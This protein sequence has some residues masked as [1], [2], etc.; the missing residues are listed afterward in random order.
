MACVH[1]VHFKTFLLLPKENISICMKLELVDLY[2][3]S[4]MYL[5]RVGSLHFILKQKVYN[6]WGV[7][8]N[9]CLRHGTCRSYCYFFSPLHD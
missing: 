3:F 1:D 7:G 4:E 9:L 6:P 5:R 8:Q 2:V